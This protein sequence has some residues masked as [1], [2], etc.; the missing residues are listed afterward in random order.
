MGGKR[1]PQGQNIGRFMG[2]RVLRR[3]CR[4]DRWIIK[5]LLW[6]SCHLCSLSS[7][8]GGGGEG[9]SPRRL[10]GYDHAGR[11]EETDKGT[12]ASTASA[13]C[14]A[15][16]HKCMVFKKAGGSC[17]RCRFH[18]RSGCRTSDD[19]ITPSSTKKRIKSEV[20]DVDMQDAEDDSA[21][22][23]DEATPRAAT[24]SGGLMVRDIVRSAPA[25]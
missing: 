6:R 22:T 19:M 17:A 3:R 18:H 24:R 12:S 2:S 20:V 14:A 15:K 13:A 4:T 7:V 9:V 5:G 11:I 16:G 23:K 21:R 10:A 1:Q 8:T 25:Y